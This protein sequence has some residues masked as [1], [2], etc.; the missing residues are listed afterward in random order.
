M[1]GFFPQV[2][3]TLFGIPIRDTVV[4][5]WIMMAL[6]AGTGA[7]LGLVRPAAMEMLVEFLD[8]T[9]SDVMGRPAEPFLP[10]LGSL[11]VF[12]AVANVIG[13]VPF[14]VT[15]TRDVN[16]PLALALIVFFS[17]HYYGIR[18]KG[19]LG[20][21]RGLASPFFLLPLEIIGQ[22]S[23]TLSLTLRLFGNIISTELIVAVIFALVPLLVPLPV[24][25]FSMFTGLLQAYIF[26]ALATV[27]IG[28]ALETDETQAS[29]RIDGAQKPLAAA[30]EDTGR[31]VA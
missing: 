11:A 20:Y 19:V 1:E 6:M 13:V 17:V 10:L 12:I 14:V 8:D 9:I 26:T 5:T 22:L 31:G 23:R 16:T 30:G 18:A 3:F 28:T 24:M 2:A 15:P 4:F 7:L 21:V 29:D 25:G 27:Y